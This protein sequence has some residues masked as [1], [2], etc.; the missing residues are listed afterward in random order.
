MLTSVIPA[1][2]EQAAQTQGTVPE[3]KVRGCFLRLIGPQ[4]AKVYL[5]YLS[6][7]IF[8]FPR[9]VEEAVRIIVTVHCDGVNL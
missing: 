4:V 7:V 8:F 3:L 2:T 1:T 5:K 6:D 9:Q